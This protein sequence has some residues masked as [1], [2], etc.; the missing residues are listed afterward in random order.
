MAR[1]IFLL[2]ILASIV[3]LASVVA[4]AVTG[5][6][7]SGGEELVQPRPSP[8]QTVAYVLMMLVMTGTAAGLVGAQ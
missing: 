2:F 7:A 8:L 6:R 3:A 4:A 1:I 5:R